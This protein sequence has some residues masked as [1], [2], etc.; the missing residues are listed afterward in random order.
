MEAHERQLLASKIESLE[1][2]AEEIRLKR[3]GAATAAGR[4]SFV[5]SCAHP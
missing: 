5:P 3:N 1:K 2:R 4:P